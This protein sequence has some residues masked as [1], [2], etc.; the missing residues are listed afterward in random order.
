LGAEVR[1]EV[2]ETLEV[3]DAMDEVAG[4]FAGPIDVEL[5][6]LAAGLEWAEEHFAVEFECRV[7]GVVV[8]SDDIG[9]AGVIE[10]ALIE[11]DHGGQGEQVEAQGI[12]GEAELM[13]E[14]VSGGADEGGGMKAAGALA[15][16][17]QDFVHGSVL[18]R[19]SS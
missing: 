10:P 8:E 18:P 13:F 12:V 17:D 2:V 11:C 9:G 7:V 3:E 15:V 5:A 1:F 19:C 14:E 16:T 4:E 6:G